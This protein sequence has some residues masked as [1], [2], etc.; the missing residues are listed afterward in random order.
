MSAHVDWFLG[1]PRHGNDRFASRTY[2]PTITLAD[3]RALFPYPAD[4]PLMY[5]SY[6][7]TAKQRKFLEAMTG[8][9]LDLERYSYSIECE[10]SE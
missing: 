4:D 1:A 5:N 10:S 8:Q 7:V 2:L 6:Q 3:L 9:L